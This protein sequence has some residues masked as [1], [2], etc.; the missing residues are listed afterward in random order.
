VKREMLFSCASCRIDGMRMPARK[1]RSSMR[2]RAHSVNW[3]T[4]VICA[5][6]I[7]S[8]NCSA[9]GRAAARRASRLTM[10]EE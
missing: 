4:S 3:S 7:G 10:W 6:G 9:A 5:E 2:M 8:G 1:T